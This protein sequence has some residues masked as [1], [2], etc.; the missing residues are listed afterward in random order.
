VV[1]T[2]FRAPRTNAFAQRWVGTARR[3]GLDW[4]RITGE[5]HLRRVLG[6]FAEHDNTARP[7]HARGLQPPVGPPAQPPGG[8]GAVRRRHRL[9]GLLHEYRRAAA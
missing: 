3:E 6:D 1:R 5:R 7:H 8:T 2:P 9:G 4:L